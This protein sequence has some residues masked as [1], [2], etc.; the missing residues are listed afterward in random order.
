VPTWWVALSGGVD[1][2]A[3]LHAVQQWHDRH[4]GPIIKAIH[5]NH[6]IQSASG[7]WAQHAAALCDALGVELTTVKVS[8]DAQSPQ[9][10][11]AAARAARY[12]AF[13]RILQENDALLLAHH[14]DDQ[15][16]TL[17]LRL[18]RGAGPVGLSGM[19]PSRPLGTGTLL[20]PWLGL[21][22]AAIVQWAEAQAI[23]FVQDP[24]NQDNRFDRN[25]L[26][27]QVLPL[28][29]QRWSGY[30][31]TLSRAAD[32][33][34][35]LSSELLAQSLPTVESVC[36]DPGLSLE[37]LNDEISVAT[38]LHRW[39]TV[40][41]ISPPG[42]TRLQ[43]FAR[44]CLS[45]HQDR[46]PSLRLTG[47]Q[48]T[49]WR[50]VIYRITEPLTSA[51]ETQSVTVGQP[52]TLA[53]GQLSWLEADGDGLPAGLTGQCRP[54]S[55]SMRLP[56]G[57]GIHKSVKQL[58]QEHGVPPWWRD[59]LPLLCFADEPYWLPIIGPLRGSFADIGADV[60]LKSSSLG[61]LLRPSWQPF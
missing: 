31:E 50:G 47:E 18:L 44:Q 35:E 48:L 34:R 20:R 60:A 38:L 49:H 17:L 24:S 37:G 23:S 58:C 51:I 41:G 22:R 46:Q 59:R 39:L 7:D 30:R 33:Q 52:V 8:V 25:F 53:G 54:I 56:S 28:I 9:G 43:E 21:D 29:S 40:S 42:R 27:N 19:P 3:L 15:A 32:L 1:S 57:G 13:E 61:P 4:G 11:E 45:A 16:E 12:G 2:A 55:P 5:V 36:G 14:R 26:R 6:D 10:P